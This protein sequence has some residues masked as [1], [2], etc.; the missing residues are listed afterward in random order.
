VF[1]GEF[2]RYVA[3][4][5]RRI[6]APV[7]IDREFGKFKLE[8]GGALFVTDLIEDRDSFGCVLAGLVKVSL[9]AG[10]VSQPRQCDCGFFPIADT[11]A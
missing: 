5:R 3:G 9:G 11:A 8:S 6:G 10:D 7:F 1:A 2:L 4:N